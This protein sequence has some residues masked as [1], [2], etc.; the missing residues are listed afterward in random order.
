MEPPVDWCQIVPAV[1]DWTCPTHGIIRP[2]ADSLVPYCPELVDGRTCMRMALK[3]VA[4]RGRIEYAEPRP[5]TC[6]HGHPLTSGRYRV[7][8][9]TRPC[10]CT[11]QGFHR[12]WRCL[13]GADVDHPRG[14][15]DT[16]HWPRACG[17]ERTGR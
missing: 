16:Q 5:A 12:T 2:A 7:G 17:A 6:R 3:A 8:L 10:R 15:D 14:C 4:V 9:G 1:G 13:F 11:P